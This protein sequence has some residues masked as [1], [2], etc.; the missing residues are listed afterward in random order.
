MMRY[1]TIEQ[2]TWDWVEI[3]CFGYY[4][5]GSFIYHNKH[6]YKVVQIEDVVYNGKR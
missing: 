5:V 1:T 3:E 2:E 4:P 6:K